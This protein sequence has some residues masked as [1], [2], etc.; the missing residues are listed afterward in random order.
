MLEKV[1][2]GGGGEDQKLDIKR[3][4]RINKRSSRENNELFIQLE[5]LTPNKLHHI[6]AEFGN[7]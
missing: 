3:N 1:E 4:P 6:S 2:E 5:Q 7:N